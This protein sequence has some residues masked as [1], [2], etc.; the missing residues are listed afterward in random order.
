MQN[1]AVLEKWQ[2]ER[3]KCRFLPICPDDRTLWRGILF[4]AG[5]AAGEVTAKLPRSSG[6]FVEDFAQ[7]GRKCPQGI[8]RQMDLC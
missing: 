8:M 6:P 4:P 2:M 1:C 7:N 5:R 3:T